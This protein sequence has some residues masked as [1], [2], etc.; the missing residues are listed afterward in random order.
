MDEDHVLVLLSAGSRLCDEKLLAD[1]EAF[2]KDRAARHPGGTRAVAQ[3][4]E[5]SSACIATNRRNLRGILELL[6]RY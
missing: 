4:L 6:S 2:F 5:A 1:A 3:G